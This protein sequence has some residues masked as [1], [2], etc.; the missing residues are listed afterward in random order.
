MIAVALLA[1]SLLSGCVSTGLSPKIVAP[2][3]AAGQTTAQ[4]LDPLKGGIIGG[5]LGETLTPREKQQGIIA[6]Y[7]ALETSFGQAPVKWLNEKTGNFG[8]VIAGAPYRV[9]QQDCRSYNHKLIR[10][11]VVTTA[12][13]SAC[14]QPNGAWLRLG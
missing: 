10:N 2:V 13:G 11:S 1:A 8:E 3:N 12:S 4:L 9:G 7:Q 14:R 6:E 5:A